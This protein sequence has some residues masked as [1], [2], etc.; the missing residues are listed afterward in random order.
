MTPTSPSASG[1]AV[2][3]LSVAS[4]A[5]PFCE[6]EPNGPSMHDPSSCIYNAEIPC[7]A[8]AGADESDVNYV[9]CSVSCSALNSNHIAQSNKVSDV[10]VPNSPVSKRDNLRCC[11]GAPSCPKVSKVRVESKRRVENLC[12]EDLYRQLIGIFEFSGF[13]G[14]S[15]LEFVKLFGRI[16]FG[17]PLQ[18][19]HSFLVHSR[20]VADPS[21]QGASGSLHTPDKLMPLHLPNPFCA[22]STLK[23][24]RTRSR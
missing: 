11:T 18:R 1:R 4:S 15:L 21:L 7:V 13:S 10:R 19:F 20:R 22:V 8:S 16:V 23:G 14:R 12:G 17:A 2:N 24:G 6:A 9:A 5:E 3:A